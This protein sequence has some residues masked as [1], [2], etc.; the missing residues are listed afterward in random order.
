MIK[1]TG[2]GASFG[3]AE[4]TVSFYRKEKEVPD[5]KTTYRAHEEETVLFSAVERVKGILF[6]EE[7]IA[8]KT[9]GKE[10]A[11][12]F[13]IH[14][15]MLEDADYAFAPAD[16]II[17]DRFETVCKCADGAVADVIYKKIP[18]ILGLNP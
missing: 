1:L 18:E 2:K 13:M 17:A 15:M 16:G 5:E 9:I 8:E 10:E 14:R 6:A 3:M 7:E 4:G 11:E 12:V